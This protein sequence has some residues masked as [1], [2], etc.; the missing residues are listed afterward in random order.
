MMNN[1]KK[2]TCY[3]ANFTVAHRVKIRES[4]KI[5]EYFDLAKEF[6]KLRNTRVT[7]IPIR[8]RALGTIPK[9]LKRR[10]EELEVKE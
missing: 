10:L 8:V 2:R 3:L 4:K 6:K 9:S 5:D 1:K 7:V